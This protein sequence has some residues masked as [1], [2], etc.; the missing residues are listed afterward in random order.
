MAFRNRYGSG[1]RNEETAMAVERPKVPSEAGERE[2]L[3]AFLEWHRATLLK[4]CDGVPADRLRER[5]VAPSSLSLLGLARHLTEVERGWF[6]RGL[7]GEKAER[8]YCT[9]EHPDGDFDNVDQADVEEAF[10]A[11]HA[12]C[13][14]SRRI[15][16]SYESLDEQARGT[17]EPLMVRWVIL[18][19]LEE[20]ARHNG[21]ADLLRERI[22]G[23]V[24]E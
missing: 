10:E 21:H 2:M 13:D 15:L 20:Y 6:R 11:W 9:A 23:T 16:A 18:H 14:S 3:E 12:E 7:A 1:S 24:G 17:D 8:L 4:K 19:M 5:T 22:D